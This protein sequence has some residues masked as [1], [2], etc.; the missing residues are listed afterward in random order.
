MGKKYIVFAFLFYYNLIFA[1]ISNQ[2][3]AHVAF[4]NDNYISMDYNNTNTGNYI[5]DGTTYILYNWH[6][7]G[8]VN[9][10]SGQ[11]TGLTKFIGSSIQ[12]I[13]GTG[14]TNYYNVLFNNSFNNASILIQKEI[15]IFGDCDFTDGIAQESG[16]GL[17]IFRDNATYSNVSDESFVDGIVR[18]IGNDKFVFPIGD[19]NGSGTFLYRMATIS[20]PL[21]ITD[22]YD[23]QY[24]WK[25]T[26]SAHSITNKESVIENIDETEYWE[27]TR[28]N[29]TSDVD[30]TLSWHSSELT[31]SPAIILSDFNKLVIVRWDGTE[32]INEGGTVNIADRTI[33]TTPSGY[34]TFTL[35]RVYIDSDGDGVPDE[36]EI[37]DG[38]D[39]NDN[40]SFVLANQITEPD[41]N[42]NNSDCDEDGITNLDEKLA[43]TDPLDPCS[44]T[45][46]TGDDVCQYVTANPLS[47]LALSDCDGGGVDNIT[48]CYRGGN[49]INS[50]DDPS[51][52]P[53][54]NESYVNIETTGDLKL[55]DRDIPIGSIYGNAL[56]F[57]SNPD[58]TLPVINTDGTYSFVSSVSGIYMFD[59]PITM[60]NGD[61]V[62]VLLTINILDPD[63]ELNKPIANTDIGTTFEDNPITMPVLA[64]DESGNILTDLINSSVLIINNPKNG[65]ATVE[66]MTGNIT[67]TPD[68]GFIGKDSLEYR[69]LD[70]DGNE[71]TAYFII[72]VLSTNA[73]NST[74]ASDDYVTTSIN[75]DINGNV[76]INDSD[77]EG[78]NQIVFAQDTS[79]SGVGHLILNSNGTF[80]FT[81][82][83]DY[84]GPLHFPYKL[85]DDNVEP[86]TSYATLYI[87]VESVFA[88]IG[89]FVWVD[90]NGDG[91]Q[92]AGEQGL[93]GVEIDLI[94]VGNFTVTQHAI[95]DNNGNYSFENVKSG[96]YYLKFYLPDGFEFTLDNVLGDDV[97]SDVDGSNG[98]GT[99]AKFNT[100][101]NIFQNKWDAGVY[102]CVQIGDLAWLD[103]NMND[104]YD[105]TETGVNGLL[106]NLYRLVN[107]NWVL[108]DIDYT[109]INPNSICGDGYYSFCT[110]PGT[111]FLYFAIPPQGLVAAQPFAGND[112][113]RDSD[114]NRAHGIGTTESFTLVS[115]Q[116]KDLSI[117]AGYYEMSMVTNSLAWIDEN[118]DGIK[119]PNETGVPNMLIDIYDINGNLYHQAYTDV[120][121][122]YYIDYL[123]AEDYYLKFHIPSD[124]N[125]Y[126]F[127]ASNQG[128][129]D[130]DSDVTN[131]YGFGT[132]DLF[133][134]A[135][136]EEKQHQDAG[137]SEGSLPLNSLFVGAEWRDDHVLVKW[138]T[139]NEIN[140]EKFIIQRAFDKNDR[141]ID[142]GEVKSKGKS[143]NSYKFDDFSK[144]KNGVYYYRIITIDNDGLR[145]ISKIVPV[146]ISKNDG[147]Y[148]LRIYPNPAVNNT[149]ISFDLPRETKVKID[150]LNIQGEKIMDINDFEYYK[151]GNNNIAVNLNQLD[152]AT[153]FIRFISENNTIFKKLYLLR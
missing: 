140:V 132:T 107:D 77:P 81:P 19:D 94:P 79:I 105:S 17:M 145:S 40:C 130:F 55:N 152:A 30:I 96:E 7:D 97:D 146:F 134:L 147:K 58:N 82:E 135:P 28:T 137:I 142:L 35:G 34:G 3:E 27:I 112:P 100:E 66:P 59:I 110:N 122:N 70:D 8:M 22:S 15:N 148:N 106:V 117:D 83:H 144:F 31:T 49:P 124:Y 68:G 36:Q 43:N 29:G 115:G 62:M 98:F 61:V 76:L 65:T 136:D 150:I 52:N 118:A 11:T 89:D 39:P 6:N 133:E 14:L 125:G 141:F 153:Y 45:Y 90:L 71:S 120:D 87:L 127:T 85:K 99:T 78:D 54:N 21:A 80:V 10:T 38:T 48:E 41:A 91:I 57:A 16:N 92:D 84:I 53:D 5:N 129:D 121:G 50:I 47:L 111:Y 26:N 60:P 42:W 64:N 86:D 72:T 56:P 151:L 128:N 20:A 18:K 25:T 149:F 44:N 46:V 102:E 126:G 37:A 13:S 51:P 131:A 69:V 24:F 143:V 109:G 67:Y 123:Q 104:V 9:F 12:I 139:A 2:T 101:I 74:T 138:L 23:A 32:W 103:Y 116:E 88:R 95:T 33:T 63:I 4:S 119:D 75:T 1:Q 93:A 114:I 73:K 113:E 108:W